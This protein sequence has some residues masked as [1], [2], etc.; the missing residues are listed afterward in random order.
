MENKLVIW[1]IYNNN[2]VE[3]AHSRGDGLEDLERF[4]QHKQF[5]DS[6]IES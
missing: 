5:C 4:L 2:L 3:V 6:V 1:D